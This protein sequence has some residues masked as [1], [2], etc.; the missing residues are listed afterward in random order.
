MRAW[1]SGSIPRLA[2]TLFAGTAARAPAA[3]T[4]PRMARRLVA[5][6]KAW[7]FARKVALGIVMVLGLGLTPLAFTSG[8]AD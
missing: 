4:A 2:A 7:A 1:S 6:G 8:A 3:R 5:S